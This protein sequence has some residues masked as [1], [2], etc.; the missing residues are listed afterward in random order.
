[1]S[2]IQRTRKIQKG[3]III[4][5]A[6]FAA[7]CYV[8]R[9]LCPAYVDSNYKKYGTY[10]L[11]EP[12]ECSV[13][14]ENPY[15]FWWS[16]D[17]KSAALLKWNEITARPMDFYIQGQFRYSIRASDGYKYYFWNYVYDDGTAQYHITV[18]KPKEDLNRIDI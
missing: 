3:A 14:Y 10:S 7:G 6:L 15:S 13:W 5:Y 1:M 11:S 18:E 9:P 16:T 4:G 8:N 17:S 12:V 2:I